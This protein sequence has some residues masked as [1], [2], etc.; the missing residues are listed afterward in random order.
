MK[1]ALVVLELHENIKV[2]R[3]FEEN[4]LTVIRAINQYCESSYFIL[5]KFSFSACLENLFPILRKTVGS[6]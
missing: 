1:L 2:P 5:L 3:L 6:R 4:H